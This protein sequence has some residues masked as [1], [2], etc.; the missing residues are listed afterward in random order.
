MLING[1]N[2]IGRSLRSVLSAILAPISLVLARSMPATIE[3]FYAP[4]V[5]ILWAFA[6]TTLDCNPIGMHVIGH[7]YIV[8]TDC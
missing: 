2:R 1:F 8:D 5:V 6:A 3:I 4:L 7:F